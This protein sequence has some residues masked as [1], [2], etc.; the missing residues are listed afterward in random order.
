VGYRLLV[1]EPDWHEHRMLRLDDPMVNLHVFGLGSVEIDRM[2]LF[3]DHLREDPDDLA[4]YERT[5]RGLARR[6]WEFVQQYADA[7][8]PVVED[9]VAR[10]SR[11]TRI[12]VTGVQVMLDEDDARAVGLAERLALPLID[13]GGVQRAGVDTATASA[14]V[15]ALAAGCPAAVL[16]GDVDADRLPGRVLRLPD[17]PGDPDDERLAR[18]V[19]QLARWG[20]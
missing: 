14:V 12:P 11:R 19:R 1:R 15:A 8:S 5:K 18:A 9:I 13:V 6:T 3:R 4:L 16:V 2:L 20:A 17:L 7:K 10:A